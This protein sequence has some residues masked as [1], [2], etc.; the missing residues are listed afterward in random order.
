MKAKDK[1][2]II[3]KRKVFTNLVGFELTGAVIA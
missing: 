2:K 3:R 1:E